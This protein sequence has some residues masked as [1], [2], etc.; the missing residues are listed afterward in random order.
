MDWFEPARAGL[1]KGLPYLLWLVPALTAAGAI[2][3]I[4]WRK[5]AGITPALLVVVLGLAAW[6]QVFLGRQAW[7]QGAALYAGAAVLLIVW[8]LVL[9]GDGDLDM[10]QVSRLRWWAEAALVALVVL[11]AVFARFD[12]FDK[13]PFGIEGDE[14]KWSV[15]VAAET[16]AGQHRWDSD[17]RYKHVPFTYWVETVFY[18]LRGISLETARLQVALLSVIAS[19]LFYLLSRQMLGPPGALVATFLLAVSIADISASR[20]SHVESQ[21][22]L[23]L[24]LSFLFLLYAARTQK[25]FWYLL[26]GL[27]TAAGLLTFD[28]FFM[29]P[30]VIGLWMTWRLLIDMR[31]AWRMKLARFGLFLTPLLLVAPGSWFYISTRRGDHVKSGTAVLGSAA[32]NIQSIWPQLLENLKQTLANFSYQRWGDFLVNRDGPV[33]NAV[34][35]PLAAMGLVYLTVRWRRGQNG[36]APLWFLLLFFPAAVL[37]GSPYVRVFYPAFPA[38][39]LLAAAAV[40]LLVSTLRG[41]AQPGGRFWL[42]VT[43]GLVVALCLVGVN[44]L[45][46]YFHEV[47]DFPERITRRQMADAASA[48]LA[49]GKMLYAPY[50]PRYDDFLEWDREFLQ[51]VAWGKAPPEHDGDIHRLIPYEELL[52][53]LS[54]QGTS[55]KGATVLYDR[56]ND[57]M[58]AERQAIVDAIRRCYPG[59]KTEIG[60]RFDALVI[61]ENSLQA[62]ACTAAVTVTAQ[63]PSGG[64]PAG[65][66]LTLNWATQ[67]AG[68]G[69]AARVEIARQTPG[70]VWLEAEDLFNSPGWY[71]E[72][73]FAPHFGGRGYLAD[74]FE[75][76]DATATV[77]LLEPG[78]YTVWARTH[79]RVTAGM[80]LTI[81]AAGRTFP[82]AQHSP[83]Q[84]DTWL[85][86]RLGEVD[87]TGTSL[88]VTLHRD[89]PS[90]RHMSVFVDALVL[91]P[92]PGFDPAKGLW[93][94]VFQSPVVPTDESKIELL[95]PGSEASMPPLS[96]RRY[97]VQVIIGKKLVDAILAVNDPLFK[98][99]DQEVWRVLGVPQA[100]AAVPA[101]LSPGEH[102]W[103]VQV[104]DEDRIISPD[105]TPGRWS[106]WTTFRVS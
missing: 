9:R 75:A 46:V 70:V 50:M 105:G 51:F 84:F 42:W 82:A 39:Y 28:T 74:A 103:R 93:P 97:R 69:T 21:I 23:P 8:L 11:V 56:G 45:Y 10:P 49:E 99:E 36:L 59:T 55:L 6:G 92:D 22:K 48:H 43:G 76:P 40:M 29:A 100:E 95:P 37:F 34:L 71:V 89:Y 4:L 47:K 66:A 44:N 61:P 1:L 57:S 17:Y 83:D 19:A 15:Q 53:A 91:S 80:P 7:A 14:A 35:I 81:S 85:W 31:L 79:R 18:R 54:A 60:Q 68:V 12:R 33:F 90:G 30:A 52:P 63:Q 25:W 27:A 58:H 78:R 102:R 2:A 96:G 87:A 62:P 106:D 73:R 64:V 65:S 16:M 86:E 26:T 20:L 88:P 94:V 77:A 13:V 5:R 3:L 38:F 104:L 72:G 32:Q 67:P 24:V 41:L 101:A 98:I